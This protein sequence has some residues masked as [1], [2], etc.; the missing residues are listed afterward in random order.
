M[1]REIE[2]A[3]L[4]RLQDAPTLSLPAVNSGSAHTTLLPASGPATQPSLSPSAPVLAS[5][6]SPSLSQ[7]SAQAVP[8][9][10]PA[11]GSPS[12]PPANLLHEPV[13]QETEPIICSP[14][15]SPLPSPLAGPQPNPSPQQKTPLNASVPVMTQ[16]G[17]L[18][19]MNGQQSGKVLSFMIASLVRLTHSQTL[20]WR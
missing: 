12:A 5:A 6:T 10:P 11:V 16:D 20:G 1:K 2:L 13:K 7:H 4:N 9:T 19:P 17:N 8:S 18:R 14:P 3:A 15:S